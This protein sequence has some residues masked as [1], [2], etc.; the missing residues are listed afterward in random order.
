MNQC[1]CKHCGY[2]RQHYTLDQCRIFRVNYGHCT[3]S[4]A[5]M[6][7]PEAQACQRFVPALPKEEAFVTREYLSKEL[8]RYIMEL[9]LLPEIEDV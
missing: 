4:R 6:C 1:I 9:E 7:R 8:L 3:C 5:K 2:F